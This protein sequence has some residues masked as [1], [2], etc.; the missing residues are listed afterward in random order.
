M[1]LLIRD[2]PW[3]FYAMARDS[4]GSIQMPGRLPQRGRGLK[5]QHPV[6]IKLLFI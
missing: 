4:R 3:D 6:E 1:G 5:S 2:V